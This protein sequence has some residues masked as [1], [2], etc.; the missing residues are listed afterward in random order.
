MRMT[1]DSGKLKW[2]IESKVVRE[3]LSLSPTAMPWSEMPGVQLRGIQGLPRELDVINLVWAR[4]CAERQLEL[5]DRSGAA[6]LFC[7]LSQ[8][9]Y[10]AR[11]RD[12]VAT[13]LT[14]SKKYS[15]E[16]DRCLM[17]CDMLGIMGFPHDYLDIM[18]EDQAKSL[19]G[20]AV[21][22]PV[23]GCVVWAMLGFIQSPGL[24]HQ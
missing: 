21:A 24:W 22:A 20:E 17:A 8:S 9:V 16:L 3:A 14:K 12:Y 7:D 4:T 13:Q 23:M 10:R 5:T 18:S 6:G 2:Q 11:S 19:I 1:E 15:Y